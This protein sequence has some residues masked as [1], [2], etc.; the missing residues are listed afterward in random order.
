MGFLEDLPISAHS[1]ELKETWL[2]GEDF[3]VMAPTGSGK[4]LGLPLLLFQQNLVEGKILIV[5]PRRVAAAKNLT[6]HATTATPWQTS[7]LGKS[8]SERYMM[9]QN[10]AI[11]NRKARFALC[12]RLGIQ[13]CMWDMSLLWRA[14]FRVNVLL[15]TLQVLLTRASKALLTH[16]L[17]IITVPNWI[18]CRNTLGL[19]LPR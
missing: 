3:A 10:H 15:H 7:L 17:L 8:F 9:I 2:E 16:V 19:H 14:L 4:S 5:Q 6:R 13:A 18:P 12:A 11:L 1:K